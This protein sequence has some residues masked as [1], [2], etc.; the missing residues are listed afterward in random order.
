M[1]QRAVSGPLRRAASSSTTRRHPQQCAR[2]TAR[3][4]AC[5]ALAKSNAAPAAVGA[6]LGSRGEESLRRQRSSPVMHT[7]YWGLRGL[8]ASSAQEEEKLEFQAETRQ[9]L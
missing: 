9:L 1:M 2:D 6:T 4:I 3:R 7:T 8:S 5:Q